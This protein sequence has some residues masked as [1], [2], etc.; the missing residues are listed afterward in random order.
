MQNHG[1]PLLLCTLCIVA[2]RPEPPAAQNETDVIYAA[3]GAPI[4][5]QA[6]V[7]ADSRSGTWKFSCRDVAVWIG[8]MTDINNDYSDRVELLS[9]GS[10]TFKSLT[11]N[12]SGEYVVTTNPTFSNS[13]V[14]TR[15]ELEVLVPVSKPIV[16]TN[17]SEVLEGHGI[18]TMFCEVTGDSPTIRWLKDGELLQYH[19]R[20]NI[21]ADNLTITIASVN[22]SD[23]GGY[24]C[25]GHNPVSTQISDLRN[26][27]VFYGPEN[28]N[29][30]VNPMDEDITLG[31]NV[32]LE[33]S[34]Q[35]IPRPEFKWFFNGETLDHRGPKLD[36]VEVRRNNSGNYT[37][38][39][40]NNMTGHYMNLTR[41]LNLIEP[42]SKPFIITDVLYPVE[43]NDTVTLTC[44]VTGDVKRI[45]WILPD[46][47]ALINISLDNVN[48]TIQSI[49]RSYSG[50]YSCQAWGVV[51]NETSEPFPVNVSY[52]PDSI[53]ITPEDSKETYSVESNLTLNCIAES[54]PPAEFEWQ[55]NGKRLEKKTQ[56]LV[57]I[58]MTK[59]D[60]GNY[61]CRAYNNITKIYVT[62][63]KLIVANGIS[64]P[65]ITSSSEEPIEY[66]SNVTLT[67][68]VS[69]QPV[70]IRWSKNEHAVP[71]TENA[72]LSE[73][74]RT[75]TIRELKRKDAGNY[76]CE[77]KGLHDWKQSKLFQLVVYYGPDDLQ[78]LVSPDSASESGSNVTLTCNA[79]SF[80]SSAFQWLLNG[81]SLKHYEEQMV[82]LNLHQN[83]TGNYTCEAFNSKTGLRKWTSVLVSLRDDL[84][85]YGNKSWI[86]AAV[87]GVLVI[88]ALSAC[89]CFRNRN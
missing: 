64:V 55:L 60:F 32:T 50:A 46:G 75:L 25:E 26:L 37:C 72:R 59:D 66:N 31:T 56:E 17:V 6:E 29:L 1:F 74:N 80:P 81:N 15:M 41:T 22:R 16:V 52:G 68:D 18:L 20:M 57:I 33:C 54:V 21:S 13:S 43:H 39:A 19:D 58:N 78:L 88:I 10:L 23:S 51:N 85:D 9:N 87:I 12:D 82:I 5:L 45:E 36:L 77:A 89:A 8:N 79:S 4:V 71:E 40:Y 49:D 73:R 11:V 70:S 53:K 2:V 35:S 76:S 38:H 67:C 65:Q 24:Q 44:K 84:Q 3:V 27:T 69:G 28:M 42:I 14:T 30:S 62:T 34:A 61:T 48:L 47:I 63:T 83:K 86:A 7:S